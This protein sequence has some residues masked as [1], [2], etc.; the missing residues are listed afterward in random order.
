[1]ATTVKTSLPARKFMALVLEDIAGSPDMVTE[2][3]IASINRWLNNGNKKEFYQVYEIADLIDWV[4][5]GN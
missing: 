2:S 3:M 5:T 4:M 1:M